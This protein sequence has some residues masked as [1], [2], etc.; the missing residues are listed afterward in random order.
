MFDLFF[1]P[2]FTSFKLQFKDKKI[3]KKKNQTVSTSM[4]WAI[5]DMWRHIVTASISGL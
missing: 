1:S 4:L 5:V 2:D 3:I